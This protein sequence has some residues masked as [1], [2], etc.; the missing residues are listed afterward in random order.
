MGRVL[1]DAGLQ[2]GGAGQG[3]PRLR[4]RRPIEAREA[5]GASAP[6]VDRRRRPR[7]P[8]P[9]RSPTIHNRR[10]R[11]LPRAAAHRARHGLGEADKKGVKG[12]A[13]WYLT[14]FRVRFAGG[15]VLVRFFADV[16]ARH[17]WLDSPCPGCTD[18]EKARVACVTCAPVHL[19]LFLLVSYTASCTPRLGG[20]LR[21]LIRAYRAA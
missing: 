14:N 17:A 20:L 21:R 5:G 11:P 3:E 6:P 10:R 1:F 9:P 4:A 18:E 8:A 16:E 2:G 13:E 19:H 15:R 7:A 12:S